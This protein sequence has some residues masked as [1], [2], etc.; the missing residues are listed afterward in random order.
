MTWRVHH[1]KVW[2]KMVS[3]LIPTNTAS[4]GARI[5]RSANILRQ[6]GAEKC[7]S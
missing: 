7:L 2:K 4:N 1:H 6:E 3:S 5:L